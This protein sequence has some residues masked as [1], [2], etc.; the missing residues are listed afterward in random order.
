[1]RMFSELWT[2][3]RECLLDSGMSGSGRDFNAVAREI[4]DLVEARVESADP[5]ELLKEWRPRFELGMRCLAR[6]SKDGAW[7]DVTCTLCQ[8]GSEEILVEFKP[9][10]KHGLDTVEPT[11]AKEFHSFAPMPYSVQVYKVLT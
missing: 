6:Y 1:M 8:N 2:K 4:A 9:T 5:E 10:G 7:Q 11:P 3:V